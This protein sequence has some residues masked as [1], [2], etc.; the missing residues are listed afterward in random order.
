MKKLPILVVLTLCTITSF[1]QEVIDEANVTFTLP[2]KWT[3]QQKAGSFSEGLV[4]YFYQ[5]EP[6]LTSEGTE[7]YPAAIFILDKANGRSLNDYA[8]KDVQEEKN[9]RLSSGQFEPIQKV[10]I[11]GIDA[12]V[13]NVKLDNSGYRLQMSIYYF[14]NNDVMVKLILNTVRDP[15]PSIAELESIIKSMK[16]K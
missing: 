9:G 1:A 16:K 10:S 14:V 2:Q 12:R 5:R 11:D 4:Q 8:S 13:A 7:A 3:L 6:V 15:N